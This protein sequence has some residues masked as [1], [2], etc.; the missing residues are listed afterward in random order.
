M[1]VGTRLAAALGAGLLLA[2][3]GRTGGGS[4]GPA[5]ST[6]PAPAAPAVAGPG[7]VARIPLP[8]PAAAVATGEGFVWALTR[9][10]APALWRI[11]PRSNRV[12]GT[13]TPLPADP[14]SLG[15]GAGSVWVTPNGADGRLV[16]VDAR[17]GRVS[18]RISAHPIYFGS[19]LAF[20]AGFVWTGND[21][22]R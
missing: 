21:D 8:A 16:R 3:S 6:G 19:V 5:G 20:G 18:A 11:D 22:E 7:I 9:Q 2:A 4:A 15:V 13:P 14:W 12:V 17:T 1:G 10:P